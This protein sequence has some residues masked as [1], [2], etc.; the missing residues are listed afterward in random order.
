MTVTFT[1][2]D[3]GSGVA[4]CAAPQTV[5]AEGG[6]AVKGPATDSA[7]NTANASVI[8]KLEKTAPVVTPPA[9]VSVTAPSAAGVAGTY[10]DATATDA[11]SG[12]S[13]AVACTPASGSTAF[14]V[15][16]NPVARTDADAASNTGSA[17]FTATVTQSVA[18]TARTTAD[19]PRRSAQQRHHGGAG[20]LRCWGRRCAF[21]GRL[22][23]ISKGRPVFVETQHAASGLPHSLNLQGQARLCRDAARCVWSPPFPHAYRRE[24][25]ADV[26]LDVV[27]RSD[28]IV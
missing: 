2:T 9:N 7:G 18:A 1:C 6:T 8:I 12:F 24:E 10:G 28:N 22:V 17:G 26:A 13:G 27:P 25:L 21:R 5:T 15:G 16:V 19:S 14:P 3:A 4:A 20:R 11:L 23:Q